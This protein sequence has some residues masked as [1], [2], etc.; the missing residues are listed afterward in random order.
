[1][2]FHDDRRMEQR[3]CTVSRSRWLADLVSVSRAVQTPCSSWYV[4][5]TCVLD[6]LISDFICDLVYGQRDVLLLQ[7]SLPHAAQYASADIVEELNTHRLGLPEHDTDT[8]SV[9]RCILFV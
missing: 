8:D 5:R 7:L 2:G 9:T 6:W 3:L 1:M 4:H